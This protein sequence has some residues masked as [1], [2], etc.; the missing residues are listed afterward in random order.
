M[1]G[2]LGITVSRS[3]LIRL[4]R[5]L[6]D[7]EIDSIAVVGVD[8]FAKR[9]GQP[10][11]TVL[12][13]M[14][15][16]QPIDVLDDRT[17]EVFATWLREHPGIQV[18]CRDRAGGFAEGAG[19]GAPDAIQVA[20]RWHLWHNLCTAVESTVRA[21]R[22]HRADL[23]EPIPEASPTEEESEVDTAPDAPESRTAIRTQERHAIVHA[24][25]EKARRTPRSVRSSAWPTRLSVSS[26]S[27]APPTS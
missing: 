13:N 20:D 4:I 7:P 6:P 18:I 26:G 14:A 9:R 19:Q 16:H 1:A 21:H 17:A 24:L 10:Y 11:A 3:L 27:R 12:I 22:A 25:L 5:A 2:Q 15:I 8:E 23:A